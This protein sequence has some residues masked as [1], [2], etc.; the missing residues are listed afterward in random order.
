MQKKKKSKFF[1]IPFTE[2]MKED[3]NIVLNE[4]KLKKYR[5]NEILLKKTYAKKEYD[6]IKNL[7]KKMK[8]QS[9]F[10]Q[11]KKNYLNKYLKSS[12]IRKKEE[13][14]KKNN[15]E[16]INLEEEIFHLK[17]TSK[18][19]NGNLLHQKKK[20]KIF[21]KKYKILLK[22]IGA[23]DR[24]KSSSEKFIRRYKMELSI[25]PIIYKYL[26][27]KNKIKRNRV[28]RDRMLSTINTNS[29]TNNLK[30]LRF[31]INTKRFK[32]VLRNSTHDF[33]NSEKIKKNN[34][35]LRSG[36]LVGFNIPKINLKSLKK[37]NS[38]KLS[39]F[40]RYKFEDEKSEKSVEEVNKSIIKNNKSSICEYSIYKISE[41]SNSEKSSIYDTN[42][43][44][45]SSDDLGN[46]LKK[47]ESILDI[48]NFKRLRNE[49][50]FNNLIDNE[51]SKKI[52]SSDSFEK[53]N[54]I[55]K[56]MIGESKK[57][58][59]LENEINI[60][61]QKF[62]KNTYI[63]K[64][65]IFYLDKE[66]KK[67]CGFRFFLK[68][69]QNLDHGKK[70]NFEK[71]FIFK[72]KDKLKGFYW[73][74]NSLDYLVYIKFLTNSGDIIVL[75]DEYDE[76]IEQNFFEENLGNLPLSEI[77]SEYLYDLHVFNMISITFSH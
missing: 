53:K 42:Q 68:N 33:L 27:M 8:K 45:T 16:I 10:L 70:T 30:K 4:K 12:E 40:S 77:K 72:R 63:K 73:G 29:K 75:G 59:N 41:N 43:S 46:N 52:I 11:K 36:N 58:Y 74:L 31:R 15:V 20:L 39:K 5:K 9:E 60:I 18:Q 7:I 76:S 2:L 57:N 13:L 1:Q 34:E 25:D 48:E 22:L 65:I 6:K 14:K 28:N 64:L 49:N 38:L 71:E 23:N 50:I 35:N 55:K 19:K 21:Q 54:K 17:Q 32:G 37:K 51:T 3:E 26:N 66:K 69:G 61:N 62:N 56:I 24:T 67:F 47:I 44:D